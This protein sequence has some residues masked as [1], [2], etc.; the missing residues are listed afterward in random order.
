M[1][2]RKKVR[3]V[4]EHF[5]DAPI[6]EQT[7]AKFAQILYDE[8][9][10]AFHFDESFD[11]YV[12]NGEPTFAKPDSVA[13][14]FI[15][16]RMWKWCDKNNIDI[17]EL[18]GEVQTA[19]FKKRGIL[20]DNY[21][22]E[23]ELEEDMSIGL[24]GELNIPDY[25]S[26]YDDDTEDIAYDKGREAK[27]KGV[28]VDM[29]PYES[30]S[31]LFYAWESGWS[32]AEVGLHES[33]PAQSGVATGYEGMSMNEGNGEV[34]DQ[35]DRIRQNV[36]IGGTY[37]DQYTQRMF[38]VDDIEGQYVC[39]TNNNNP[40]DKWNEDIISFNR[41]LNMGAIEFLPQGAPP[42]RKKKAELE[43]AEDEGDDGLQAEHD[44]FS[45]M[46]W[47]LLRDVET[48]PEEVKAQVM[49]ICGIGAHE[50]TDVNEGFVDFEADMVDF[51][52]ENPEVLGKLQ[53]FVYHKEDV[54]T[55]APHPNDSRYNIM[56]LAGVN[57][58][59]AIAGMSRN[60]KINW[61]SWNDP[62]GEYNDEAFI[63]D[64][65]QPLTDEQLAR[66]MYDQI[67][68]GNGTDGQEE[69]NEFVD[70]KPTEVTPVVKEEPEIKVGI[71]YIVDNKGKIE[72]ES[73]NKEADIARYWTEGINAIE[74]KVIK[75]SKLNH[76]LKTGKIVK[77][78]YEF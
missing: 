69:L 59:N 67:S 63:R 25:E 37:Y 42:L 21:G 74:P 19:E 38:T 52:M 12:S 23:E 13:F 41:M 2:D 47:N 58:R 61:L 18:A 5:Y 16:D 57:L 26:A 33:L 73:I 56:D 11:S 30:A 36:K 78:E 15:L 49:N 20:P 76:L 71:T 22:Q 54:M 8:F 24:T 14:D 65:D 48:M 44:E 17:H 70:E 62:N 60:E 4:I 46:M 50:Y 31:P 66:M 7:I 51:M 9:D 3:A 29:N 53:N 39:C 45:D 55:E 10:L 32:E 72:I 77:E 40:D 43:L 34:A 75:L 64:G 35:F 28:E 1:L 68:R 27:F 6:N